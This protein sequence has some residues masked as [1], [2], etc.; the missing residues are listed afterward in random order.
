MNFYTL[1]LPRSRSRWLSV[2]LSDDHAHCVHEGLSLYGIDTIKPSGKRFTGSADTNPMNP[3]R[4]SGRLLIV[5][6]N[7][8]ECVESFLKAFDNPF[9]DD[10][11]PFVESMCASYKNRLDQFYGD[12]VKRVSFESL[13]DYKTVMAVADFLRPGTSM[14]V[15]RARAFCDTRISTK[16]RDL[17][18][19]IAVTA[20][21]HKMTKKQ[22]YDAVICGRIS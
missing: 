1:G 17:T 18:Y 12:Q 11:R 15:S 19:S 4:R 8:D 5:E 9:E 13:D 2:L 21:F 6:R 20:K 3:V 14:T 16:N 22:F 10:F 7:A